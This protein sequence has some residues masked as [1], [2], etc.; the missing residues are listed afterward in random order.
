MRA[1]DLVCVMLLGANAW[2]TCD[3]IVERCFAAAAV[4]AAVVFVVAVMMMIAAA[5]VVA[6]ITVLL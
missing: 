1:P 6:A 5:A 3:C 4:V 2:L